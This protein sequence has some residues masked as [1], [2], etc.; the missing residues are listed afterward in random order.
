[1]S[2]N[3]YSMSKQLA[4]ATA[5]AFGASGV[6]LADD[7]S[8]SRFGGDSYAYFNNQSIDKSPSAWRQANPQGL[9]ERVLQAYSRNSAGSAWQL[10]K[11]VF[12]NIASDPT[13]KQTHPNGLTERELEAASSSSLAMWQAPNG[14]RVAA[15]QSNVAQSP[16]GE[17]F[18]SRLANF[19]H[20]ASGK[21]GANNY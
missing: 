21:T 14:S 4:V 13:F 16:S 12:T 2:R 10:D 18:A 17:T 5:L 20:P 11:P 7:S 1:M 8:L 6:A 3:Q 9:S 19:F 15:D